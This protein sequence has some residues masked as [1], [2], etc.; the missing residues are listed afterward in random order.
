VVLARIWRRNLEAL[1]RLVEERER[2]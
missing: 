1:K 2:A